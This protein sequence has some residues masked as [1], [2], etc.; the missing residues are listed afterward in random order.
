MTQHELILDA[1]AQFNAA[2]EIKGDT[3]K[4]NYNEKKGSSALLVGAQPIEKFES[5]KG[6]P[7]QVM[8]KKQNTKVDGE[9]WLLVEPL[10]DVDIEAYEKQFAEANPDNADGKQKIL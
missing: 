7:M 2:G 1:H 6:L 3:F 5:F 8:F 10:A 4:V 9:H